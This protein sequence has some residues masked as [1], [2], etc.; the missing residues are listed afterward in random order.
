M[1]TRREFYEFEMIAI[2]KKLQGTNC[3]KCGEATC[4]AFAMKVKKAQAS[5]GD[6]PFIEAGTSGETQP[7]QAT[8]GFSNYEQVSADLE[9]EALKIDFRE[10]AEAVGGEYQSCDNREVIRLRMLTRDYELHKDGLFMDDEYCS[11]AW[12]KIIVYD[13]LRRQGRKPLAGEWISLGNF[14]H[15]ASHVKAFQANAERN[16]IETFKNDL[17]GLKQRCLEIGGTEI[18][19]SIKADY[20][21]CFDLLPRVPLYLS[22]WQA[23]EEFDP[24]CKI[25]FDSAAE[26][27]IDIEYLAYLLELFVKELTGDKR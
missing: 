23:D 14:P 4:M 3:G 10:A 17:D 13:Y 21:V 18:G 16:V 24:D 20:T 27:H 19:S 5:L 9:K 7:Q 15:T 11:D 25:Q 8:T 26:D 12:T 2:Y 6:C 1:P 22:F